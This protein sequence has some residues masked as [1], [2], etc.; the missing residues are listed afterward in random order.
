MQISGG[1]PLLLTGILAYMA[2]TS[3]TKHRSMCF[4]LADLFFGISTCAAQIGFGYIL[5]STGY[6]VA[7]ITLQGLNV[8]NLIFI[9]LFV[10]ETISQNLIDKVNLFTLKHLKTSVSVYIKKSETSGRRWRLITLL[11]IMMMTNFSEIMAGDVVT[12]HLLDRP[13]C[14]SSIL[15]GFYTGILYL[16][17][18]V[19]GISCLVILHRWIGD[20]GL[21]LTGCIS[22]MFFQSLLPIFHYKRDLF[23]GEI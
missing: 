3:A 18:A 22:G 5:N 17:K 2:D 15:I 11:I 1:A 7:Y 23:I 20:L 8:F 4:F 13:L 6:I 16:I 21:L 12:Y 14:F 10:K 19:A 9:A